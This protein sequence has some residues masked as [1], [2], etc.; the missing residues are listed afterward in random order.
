MPT[1]IH[2]GWRGVTAGKV[3][4]LADQPGHDFIVGA[5]AA[6]HGRVR[7]PE[8]GATAFRQSIGEAVEGVN[9]RDAAKKHR[10]S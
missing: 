6:I 4:Y 7:G 1:D 2:R 10:E 9:I 8:A 5:G 3:P